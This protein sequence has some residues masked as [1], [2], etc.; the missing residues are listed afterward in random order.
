MQRVISVANQL[1]EAAATI[2]QLQDCRKMKDKEL[3][4]EQKTTEELRLALAKARNEW[5]DKSQEQ[6]RQNKELED[7]VTSLA[8][9]MAEAK[10]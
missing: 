6:Q 1:A 2:T 5:N 4:T 8:Q 9:S 10:V 7:Q 3:A